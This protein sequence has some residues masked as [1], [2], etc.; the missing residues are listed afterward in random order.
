ML[1]RTYKYRLYPTKTQQALLESQL[2]S[3]R[4]LYNHFLEQRK[5]AY[6]KDKTTITCFDQIKQIPELKKEKPE[7]HE[8]HSQ[9]LQDV[10]R[11]LDKSFQNFFRRVQENKKGKSQKPGYPR[12]KGKNRYD[13]LVYPQSGFEL[14]NNKFC[15]VKSDKVG[16]KQFNR[17][18]ISK[19]GSVK[20][21]LHRP[22]KGTIKTLTIQRTSTHKWY[23]CFSVEI[24]QELPEK[25]KIESIK[26][27]H[28]I[29]ID[30]GLNSFVTTSQ[31]EK[32]H[33]PR[34]LRE[35]EEQLAKIQRKHS[36]KKLKSKN[37]QK[38]RLKI[39]A[40][41]ETINNQ[42]HDFLHKLSTSLVNNFQ[43]IA[44]EK[45]NIKGLVR[46]KYLAKS[47]TDAAWGKFLQMLTYKAEEA[48]LYAIG[49]N[50]QNT[51]QMCSGCRERVPK[52]L[53]V[54]VHTCPECGLTVDRDINAAKN[55]L[56]LGLTTVGT[57]ES[58]TCGVEGLLSTV[59]Q[60]AHSLQ[61]V[62]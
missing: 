17:V 4:Y 55:I 45:L 30:V 35:S 19:I 31:Q 22:I 37:R 52:T 24:N 1:K 32:I 21:I 36:K 38:S 10:P 39:A 5:N 44:F 54:R 9:V 61:G 28:M 50:P 62:E 8:I 48:G 59:K 42:R 58:N 7:L 18:N 33:N 60:E 34:Y 40:L 46:N 41:H 3:C 13:S 47:I 56:T 51:S 20:I 15:P 49:V 25:T 29:G 23:A 27:E 43:F 26:Q 53:A 11:R 2:S 57:T 14:K 12:F 16:V 6:E